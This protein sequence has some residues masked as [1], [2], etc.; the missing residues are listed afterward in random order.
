M[1]NRTNQY[2]VC[3][4]LDKTLH[5]PESLAQRQ[6]IGD[7][8]AATPMHGEL[9]PIWQ[10]PN[11]RRQEFWARVVL[12]EEVLLT[13]SLQSYQG[14]TANNVSSDVSTRNIWWFCWVFLSSYIV[15]GC[16]ASQPGSLALPN[17]PELLSN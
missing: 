13:P 16:I 3:T 2:G 12:E 6:Q 7:Q 1:L 5:F 9:M 4:L 14:Q 17:I 10:P 11:R 15:P 8:V